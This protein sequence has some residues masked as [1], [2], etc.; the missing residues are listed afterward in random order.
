VISDGSIDKRSALAAVDTYTRSLYEQ[1]PNYRAI[2][3]QGE[4]S[5]TW[6]NLGDGDPCS[7]KFKA[8]VC[9][10]FGISDMVAFA[11]AQDK[12]VYYV[13]FL[14]AGGRVFVSVQRWLLKL[15]GEVLAAAVRKHFSYTHAIKGQHSFL[16]GRV[17]SE[18]P[19][20]VKLTSRERLVCLGILTGHTSE[21]IALNLSI[22]VNSVL[23]YRKRL[24]EKLGISSQNE[25]FVRILSALLAPTGE[26]MDCRL[27]PEKHSRNF[28]VVRSSARSALALSHAAPP[29]TNC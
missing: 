18:G 11:V 7:A 15:V 17:L 16:I 19:A 10:A 12:V 13:A 26:L 21:S 9:A 25:L 28:A 27:P 14:R 24:Y 29:V 22:S 8:S 4:G 20:F 2:Q 1:D 3:A 5:P 6:F 23:T